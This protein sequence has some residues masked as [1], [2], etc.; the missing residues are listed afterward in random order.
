MSTPAPAADR[1]LVFGLLA[2]QMDFVSGEQ[3]L[4]AMA[5]WML[6]KATPLGQILRE[7]GVLPEEDL[8][9]LDGLVERHIRRHGD[10]QASLA[11]LHL[12]TDVHRR[13]QALADPDVQ[14][15]LPPA[16]DP[17]ATCASSL[18]PTS[19]RFRR[20]RSHARGGLGEVFVALDEELHRE[21]ALKEIQDQ[22]ADR[23]DARARFLLEAEITGSLE[24][25][26]IVPVYG[27][28]AY[29]D[30][31][32]YYAMR[33]IRGES[34]QDA[35]ARF[36][37]ADE[38][39]RRDP[40]ERSLALRDL[41][42]RFLALC[43]AVA[44][45]HARGIVHRD[46][47]PANVMLGEYG[48]TLV[49]DWGLARVLDQAEGERTTAERPPLFASGSRTAPTEMGQVVG[50]PAFMPPEQADGRRDLVGPASD[51]FALGATLYALLTGRP[52]YSGP[53]VLAQAARAEVVPARKVKATVPRPLEAICARAM[54]RVPGDRY[55]TVKALAQDVQRWLADEPVSAWR[56]P[57][58]GRL[59]RWGRRH[60]TL[61][62]AAGVLLA[63][64]VASLAV[65]LWAVRREQARTAL[66]LKQAEA[67]L[68][69]AR[70]AGAQLFHAAGI[71][72]RRGRL[73]EALLSYR[74]A[75][76]LLAALV[77]AYP[78][79]PVY[80][81]NLGRTHNNLGDILVKLGRRTEA[82]EEHRQSLAIREKLVGEHP[83]VAEHWFDL[84]VTH[85]NR[86][87]LETA[88]NA[89]KSCRTACELGVKLVA[90]HPQ[91]SRYRASLAT[92]HNNLALALTQRGQLQEA[93]GEYDRAA[94]LQT[95]LRQDHPDEPEHTQDL[96]RT[97]TNRG[98]LLA[99]RQRHEDALREYQQ[100]RDLG[101]KL[102]AAYPAVPEY[103]HYLSR[104][105]NNLGSLLT[106]RN[107]AEEALKEHQQAL[108]LRQRLVR[109]HAEVPVYESDLAGS[110]QNLGNALNRL[111][112]HEEALKA[113]RQSVAMRTKLARAQPPW[114]DEEHVL[115]GGHFNLGQ[116]LTALGRIEEALAEFENVRAIEARLVK[117]HPEV[118]D[119]RRRRTRACLVRGELLSRQG[120][121]AAALANLQE[122]LDQLAELRRL[123]PG[124][125]VY[126]SL[127]RRLLRERAVVL[128][129]LG[130]QREA[131]AEWE[132]IL[133]ET[134]SPGK[135]VLRGLR[136]DSRVRA[137]DYRRA[138]EDAEAA[139]RG[140]L[141]GGNLYNLACLH[142]LIAAR[143]A[144]DASRPLPQRDKESE[145]C[146]RQALA[147][148][149][150]A[151]V[152]GYFQ[153]ARAIAGLDGD[154]DL[155]VLRGRDD[156]R[157]FRAGLK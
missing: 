65:G 154:A 101:K 121:F 88:E 4:D 84:L 142:A 145:R 58:T 28:G 153:S 92:A 49:V 99:Q 83:E 44:F 136:G 29:P 143:A 75:R 141:N 21:V 53:G 115:A 54:A 130:R 36:H 66:A 104:A 76:D 19:A 148:L 26:A 100:A 135:A 81:Q 111:G 46:L 48:E 39:P 86:S 60:R 97:L 132:R 91:E 123:A 73:R 150:R 117:A 25:P 13:L 125:P 95:R 59:R 155:E 72:N 16:P 93:L 85:V 61:V 10:A 50:T 47:K 120:R 77:D 15:S 122:G 27:L 69:L 151:R 40:G 37:Q 57:W 116:V 128:T 96:V 55:A 98:M 74:R 3:L 52:P 68:A 9:A 113:Y 110:Y 20:L 129:R 18:L 87:S 14:A 112:R 22:H 109:E 94:R 38:D 31:R 157:R 114:A 33:L 42:G 126:E 82:I 67:N 90:E 144:R 1:N 45:A 2:L 7:R 133:E 62:A 34:L 56:E 124:E 146:C 51:V 64:G 23:P 24:H 5:A 63:V 35:I 138:A 43:N 8:A 118:P 32:P 152:V 137:G 79:E 134:P 139:G 156:Y 102:V 6:R 127:R 140:R 80:R 119:F 147:V 89:V 11:A 17:F 106:D 103:R 12:E 71:E 149:E 107:R 105:L 78:G 70:D 30:G 108:A 131:D 41:L